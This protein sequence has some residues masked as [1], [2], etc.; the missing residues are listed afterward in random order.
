MQFDI[1][2]AWKDEEYR[3]SLEQQVESPVGA[4]EL[5]ESELELINGT[6]AGGVGKGGGVTKSD[7]S[8][9]GI[10]NNSYF[11]HNFSYHPTTNVNLGENNNRGGLLGL[12]QM[13]LLLL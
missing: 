13:V 5:S 4:V 10:K 9:V 11:C 7:S 8:A 3:E 2:R 12:L 6:G 1:T